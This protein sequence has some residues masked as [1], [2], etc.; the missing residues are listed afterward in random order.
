MAASGAAFALRRIDRGDT[1]T[2]RGYRTQMD[3]PLILLAPDPEK[4]TCQL[5]HVPS[6]PP[7]LFDE[8]AVFFLVG[9]R[10]G[11]C[12]ESVYRLADLVG[13]TENV[14]VRGSS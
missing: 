8:L 7:D 6:T 5:N 9:M 1:T 10:S 14:S 12:P 2:G 4:L 11:G 3:T 13:S